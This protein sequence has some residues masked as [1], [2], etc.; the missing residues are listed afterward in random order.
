MKRKILHLITGLEI[1]GTEMMLLKTLPKLQE[2]FDNRV[3]CIMGRGPIGKELEKKGIEVHYLE[4]NKFNIFKVILKF[5]KIVRNFQPDLLVN[6]LIHADL[7]G[8]IFGKL[9]GIK[10]I[11]SNQR[12]FFLNWKFLRVFDWTTKFLVDKYIVQTNF[13]KNELI[14][15]LRLK[16]DIIEVIPNTI[17]LNNF[18]ISI[19]KEEKI[20]SLG[21]PKNHTNI[22]SVGNLRVGKGYEFLLAAFEKTYKKYRKINLLIVGEGDQ[23]DAYLKQMKNYLS[24]KNIFFLG[25][26]TD[27]S[28]LLKMSDIFVLATLSEG[29]SN[30]ILEAMAS[31][32]P[33][34]TTDIEVNKELID[35][36]KSGL[37]VS[38]KNSEKISECFME[39][40][41]NKDKMIFLGRN[42]YQ[43]IKDKFEIDII[44]DKIKNSYNSILQ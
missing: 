3:C 38:V 8:R 44:I 23:K 9:F 25:R 29:M 22:I 19:N 41:N 28:E 10:K 39:L 32:M 24:K 11:A 4:L 30:A 18:N 26:R 16:S 5:R 1:G 17:N 33:I 21:I 36:Q 37:L 12:G 2:D 13:A 34:V 31:K 43:K 35:H 42:A 14:K 7:F 6:Y 40:I 27:V 20:E 15:L